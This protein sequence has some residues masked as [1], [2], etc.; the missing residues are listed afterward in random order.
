MSDFSWVADQ[1]EGD[2]SQDDLRSYWENYGYQN[3]CAYLAKPGVSISVTDVAPVLNAANQPY[4]IYNKSS[5]QTVLENTGDASMP[6]F[7]C[8]LDTAS[9]HYY[10]LKTEETA[11]SLE[12]YQATM[13]QYQSDREAVLLMPEDQRLRAC[14]AMPSQLLATIFRPGQVPGDASALLQESVA[15]MK[16]SIQSHSLAGLG[17]RPSLQHPAPT[18]SRQLSAREAHVL[19]SMAKEV[20]DPAKFQ[21][22]KDE[23]KQLL[24]QG[25]EG[26]SNRPTMDTDEKFAQELQDEEFKQAGLKPGGHS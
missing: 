13:H 5:A 6:P 18:D 21:H 17:S 19:D 15:A 20:V 26:F 7:E 10:L 24:I 1:P 23:L 11:A 22:Y 2:V 25:R 8:A 3:Y 4:T 14:R 12:Q 9:G 16:A